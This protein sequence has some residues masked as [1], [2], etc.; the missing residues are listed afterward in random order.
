MNRYD[1][2]KD[3]GPHAIDI[4]AMLYFSQSLNAFALLFFCM[5]EASP[6]VRCGSGGSHVA[7]ALRSMKHFET[8][9]TVSCAMG[10]N[11][12]ELN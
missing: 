4:L 8:E 2:A 5:T 6:S 3:I 10:T 9:H 12:I 1:E 11:T 7:Q